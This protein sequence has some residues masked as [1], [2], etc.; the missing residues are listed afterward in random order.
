MCDTDLHDQEQVKETSKLSNK[1]TKKQRKRALNP[2]AQFTNYRRCSLHHLETWILRCGYFYAWIECHHELKQEQ[3]FKKT[4]RREPARE[5]ECFIKCEQVKSYMENHVT[6]QSNETF[7]S[8]NKE[9][10]AMLLPAS[11]YRLWQAA[12]LG[13]FT[14]WAEKTMVPIFV[15]IKKN[16]N[17]AEPQPYLLDKEQAETVDSGD[18]R[19]F[20]VKAESACEN[21]RKAAEKC[22]R[23]GLHLLYVYSLSFEHTGS[24]RHWTT[25]SAAQAEFETNDAY[26]RLHKTLTE[27]TGGWNIWH[28]KLHPKKFRNDSFA[29]SAA[30]ATKDVAR[31]AMD[32]LVKCWREAREKRVIQQAFLDSLGASKDAIGR[33]TR[34][35]RHERRAAAAPVLPTTAASA[36]VLPTAA[37]STTTPVFPGLERVRELVKVREKLVSEPLVQMLQERYVFVFCCPSLI[38]G[39]GGVLAAQGRPNPLSC[40]APRL[41]HPIC[42]FFQGDN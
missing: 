13:T 28:Y 30:E 23:I 16:R 12:L 35:T 27:E 18:I 15:P 10:K 2:S 9:V 17:T 7:R 38:F 41:S 1:Q 22:G 40:Y 11:I 5:P 33:R 36:P 20:S 24:S 21:C 4:G 6:H 8:K 26:Q 34:F 37:V 32:A 29:E 3:L 14:R 42:G 31:D 25:G 19:L 39:A